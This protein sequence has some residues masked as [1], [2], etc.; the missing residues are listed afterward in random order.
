M[1][2]VSNHIM[3]VHLVCDTQEIKLLTDRGDRFELSPGEYFARRI[4][5]TTRDNRSQR[6]LLAIF[7]FP[8]TRAKLICV[9]LETLAMQR[10]N[11][12]TPAKL[13][14]YLSVVWIVRFENQRRRILQMRM[15]DRDESGGGAGRNQ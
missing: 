8:A 5:R 3:F 9:E 6:K 10:Q 13:I 14:K 12:R 7:P 11:I 15:R 1:S 4:C 2:L